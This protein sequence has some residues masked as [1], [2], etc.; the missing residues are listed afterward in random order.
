MIMS[1]ILAS[2]IFIA[3]VKAGKKNAATITYTKSAR[4]ARLDQSSD[5]QPAALTIE[6]EASSQGCINIYKYTSVML[7][8]CLCVTELQS[9]HSFGSRF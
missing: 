9:V 1:T 5:E 7:M 4:F 8:L 2:S 6:M 3:L